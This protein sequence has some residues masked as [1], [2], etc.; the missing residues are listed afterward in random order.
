MRAAETFDMINQ[1]T[2]PQAAETSAWNL[3]GLTEEDRLV[4]SG[5]EEARFFAPAEAIIRCGEYPR[6]LFL[7]ME[8]AA[9]VRVRHGGADEGAEEAVSEV[10]RVE[11]GSLL[12]ELSFVS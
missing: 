1:D 9:S 6:A 2:D 5:L 12:G 7:I 10:A 3:P 8:G 11:G 4:L